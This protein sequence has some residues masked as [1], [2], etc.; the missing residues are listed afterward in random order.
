M[1]L[2]IRPPDPLSIASPITLWIAALEWMASFP[3]F[4]NKPLPLAIAKEAICGILSGLDSKIIIKTPIGTVIKLNS[5]P[6][7][8][9]LLLLTTPSG[10]GMSAICLMPDARVSNFPALNFS[11]LRKDR[12]IP[13]VSAATTSF[14]FSSSKNS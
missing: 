8:S 4:N 5:N 9:S 3:P 6:L 11:R 14:I 13:S 7:A 10:S 1:S 2:V 12:E